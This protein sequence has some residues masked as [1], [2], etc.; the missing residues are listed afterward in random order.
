MGEVGG[1]VDPRG[2]H[3]HLGRQEEKP[4][5]RPAA[6][7]PAPGGGETAVHQTEDDHRGGLAVARGDARPGLAGQAG[8]DQ[9]DVGALLRHPPVGPVS[10]QQPLA[11]LQTNIS[12]SSFSL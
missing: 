8:L 2:P 3:H 7:G 4:E 1:D 9:G 6:P 11:N 12:I 10:V 5:E